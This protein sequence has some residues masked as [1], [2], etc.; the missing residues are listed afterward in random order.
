MDGDTPVTITTPR[1][2]RRESERRRMLR[3]IEVYLRECYRTETAARVSELS[4]QLGLHR[5]SLFRAAAVLGQPL[6]YAMRDLQLEYAATLLTHT[7]KPVSAVA[8]AAAFGTERTFFRSF[9]RA[10]GVT[11]AMYRQNPVEKKR[12]QMSVDEP[13][14]Y[15]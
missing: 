1:S 12:N 2:R 3:S 6:R 8:L 5:A 14:A 9:K 4:A 13:P 10:F 7:S 11:P 15:R